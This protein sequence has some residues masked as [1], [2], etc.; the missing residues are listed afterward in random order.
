VHHTAALL[1]YG[2]AAQSAGILLLID[3]SN[4]I[5]RHRAPQSLAASLPVRL[6]ES[7]GA[8]SELTRRRDRDASQESWRVFFRDVCVG[9]ISI[10]TGNPATTD[11]WAWQCGLPPRGH[12][13]GTAE[14]FFKARAAFDA[15]WQRLRP[16]ITEA[17]LEDYRRDRDRTARKYALFDAGLRPPAPEWEPGKPCSI[18]MK[19]R[20]GVIFNSH[21]LDDTVV[22]VSHLNARPE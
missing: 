1:F 3:R 2:D 14:D 19:C 8:M 15:A 7:L 13:A 22:H 17:D 16:K 10:R 18:W 20:C 6:A 4:R 21:Q 12:E 11:P 9:S 5:A